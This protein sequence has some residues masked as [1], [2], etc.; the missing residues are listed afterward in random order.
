MR[1]LFLA[2]NFPPAKGGIEYV[3][4]HLVLGLRKAGDD[5]RVIA[6]HDPRQE[7]EG[8]TLRPPRGGLATYLWFAL[9]RSW[10]MLRTFPADL[11]VCPGIVTAPVA[12]VL[13]KVHRKPY[14]VLAHGSDVTHGGLGYRFAMRFFFRAAR[15]VA[16]NSRSTAALMKTAGCSPA[17]VQVIHPGVQTEGFP[18]MDAARRDAIREAHGLSQRH[19]L[20]ALGRLIRRKGILE[21]VEHVMPALSQAIPDILLVVVGGDATDSLVH[22]EG[23]M[24]RIRQ[25][26]AQRGLDRHVRL[27]GPADDATVHELHYAADIHVLPALQMKDDVEGFGIVLIEAALAQVPVVASRTGG[28]PEA[29]VDGETGL[30]VD[31]ED[32]DAMSRAIQRLLLDGD[33]RLRLGRQGRQRALSTFDW[34]L[35]VGEYRTFFSEVIAG[36]NGKR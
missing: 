33:L 11:I 34:P 15:G 26:I 6:R 36:G 25:Q 9:V 14:V 18:P 8:D 19:V 28:I 23:M 13:A 24:G 3:A 16:S 7:D 29:V 4:W 12:W 21:F 10:R 17:F 22:K 31:A 30:L 35:I 2:W 32:W 1:I 27:L 5:V 20:F